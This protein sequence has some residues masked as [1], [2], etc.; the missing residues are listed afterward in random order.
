M[1]EN[2]VLKWNN[3]QNIQLASG[4]II[5]LGYLK[6]PRAFSNPEAQI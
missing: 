3:E 6:A 5:L 1:T 2:E 4:V